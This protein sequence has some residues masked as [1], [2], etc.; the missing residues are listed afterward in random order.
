[1]LLALV[2]DMGYHFNY[3]PI[4]MTLITELKC[5][6]V[7]L[8]DMQY[9]SL[10]K[11]NTVRLLCSQSVGWSSASCIFI[12]PSVLSLVPCLWSWSL[13]CWPDQVK[14]PEGYTNRG[15]PRKIRRR[16]LTSYHGCCDAMMTM[17]MDQSAEWNRSAEQEMR[18]ICNCVIVLK[19]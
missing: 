2:Y 17:M 19:S 16:L 10:L 1:M 9:L 12:R 7:S 11:I 15:L 4:R 13:C 5:Y 8:F 14:N 18:I 3:L 6:E